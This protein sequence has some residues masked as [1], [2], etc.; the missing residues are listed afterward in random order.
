M[1]QLSYNR[2]SYV[3]EVIY[4]QKLEKTNKYLTINWPFFVI[5]SRGKN[6]PWQKSLQIQAKSWKIILNPAHVRNL[7]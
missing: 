3:G 7:K 6:E 1:C 4:I 5:D 2:I